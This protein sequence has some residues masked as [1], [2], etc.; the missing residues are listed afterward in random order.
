MNLTQS[1][2]LMQ[3]TIGNHPIETYAYLNVS[4]GGKDADGNVQVVTEHLPIF[5]GT[6][7]G[8]PA[9]FQASIVASDLQGMVEM[10]GD[11]KLLG[12]GLPEY[13]YD[14]LQIN[15]PQL[16]PEHVLVILCGDLYA[17]LEKRGGIGDVSAVWQAFRNYFPVIIGVAG[18]HDY[19]GDLVDERALQSTPGIHV[20]HNQIVSVGS[21]RL[22]GLG[23]IMGRCDKPN[24][25][26]PIDYLTKL[27]QLL[28]KQP[29]VLKLHQS[30]GFAEPALNGSV[31]LG[32]FL[33]RK[34]R[35]VIF[36]GHTHWPITTIN[37]L[38]QTQ[39]VNGH[40]KLLILQA[41]T[42]SL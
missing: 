27:E 21:L 31:E 22:A 10:N 20:L 33:V 15:Y 2:I 38:N 42:A 8:L 19:F 13:L 1:L 11:M 16:A 28:S 18:N 3:L 9:P 14:L 35:C 12:E 24:R 32:R 23:G 36:C 29:D 26:E 4:P 40:G 25:I 17:N 39:I 7:S 5:E 41:P 37:L 30:P 6:I 34:K